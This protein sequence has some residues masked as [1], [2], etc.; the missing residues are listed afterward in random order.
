MGEKRMFFRFHVGNRE[1]IIPLG[2]SGDRR[3]RS[4]EMGLK[5]TAWEM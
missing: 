1:G 3:T 2:E 5:W 4:I